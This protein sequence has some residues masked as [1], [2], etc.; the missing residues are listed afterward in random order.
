ME[1]SASSS[2][3][4]EEDFD[5]MEK[6]ITLKFVIHEILK[7]PYDTVTFFLSSKSK[8]CFCFRL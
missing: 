5:L 3:Q 7:F 2:V 8:S 4:F 1:Y 6:D